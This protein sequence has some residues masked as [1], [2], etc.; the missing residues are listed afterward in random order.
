M[1]DLVVRRADA[2][3][4]W[5]HQ[6]LSGL[7]RRR[8]ADLLRDAHVG[9]F[10]VASRT[11][12]DRGARPGHRARPT[13]TSVPL[14][15][16]GGRPAGGRPR[17]C[18]VDAPP[19]ASCRRAAARR[20]CSTTGRSTRPRRRSLQTA[21]GWRSNPTSPAA[22]RSSSATSADGR[23]VAVSADGGIASALE[24]RRTR[25]L[26]RRRPAPD[27]RGLRSGARA[28]VAESRSSVFDR[29]GARVLAVTPSG[30][31]L[32]EE[33]PRRCETALVIVQWLRELRQRLPLPVTAPPK[34]GDPMLFRRP[35]LR[36]PHCSRSVRC[37]IARI[38]RRPRRRLRP[39]RSNQA[40]APDSN[41]AERFPMQS[42]YKL[43]IVMAVLDQVDRKSADAESEG[44]PL[45]ARHGADRPQP[46]TRRAPARRHRRQR[47]RS[48]SRRDRRQRRHRVGRAAASCRRWSRA[49]TA[50]LRGLGIGDMAVATTERAMSRDPMAQYQNY[51]TPRA[52]VDL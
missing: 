27:A 20:S 50:Y 22:P 19:S 52:A 21:A 39:G 24:R 33:R 13:R 51:S 37:E 18:R 43:P 29:A 9:T 6:R 49:V 35:C 23:R 28:Q 3:H 36:R 46:D 4:L 10:T 15:R 26:F 16:R 31:L 38:Q 25:H 47:P 8:P 48:D 1:A 41:E 44:Q 7:V 32:I 14:L 11:V 40:T 42:V 30:R 17:R 45:G 34:I 2:R 5:R 12:A